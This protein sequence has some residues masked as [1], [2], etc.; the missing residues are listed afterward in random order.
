MEKEGERTWGAPTLR[1]QVEEEKHTKK[2]KKKQLER[3]EG[4][5]RVA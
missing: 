3:E 1:H 2:V 5:L 4:L